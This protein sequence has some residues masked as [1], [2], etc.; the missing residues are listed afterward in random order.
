LNTIDKENDMEGVLS[1][2]QRI[3]LATDGT[4]CDVLEAYLA[5]TINVVKLDHDETTATKPI[6]YLELNANSKIVVRRVL[7]RGA[8]SHK[9][10][11]YAESILVPDTLEQKLRTDLECTDKSIGL[12]MIEA[13]TE[14]FR[15]IMDC[16]T[17]AASQLSGLFGID[18]QDILV[19]RTYRIFAGGKPSILITEK[20]PLSYF[21][22]T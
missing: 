5:E 21:R 3:L 14:T 8:A 15:E 6:P 1:P 7:L 10:Y 2:F 12:L 11:I 22:N 17:E 9:N 18:E 19:S 20:F 4:V 13:R 16:G